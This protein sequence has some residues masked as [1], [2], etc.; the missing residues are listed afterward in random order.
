[1][2]LQ[3]VKIFTAARLGAIL[4][5]L[6]SSRHIIK[7]LT[8]VFFLPQHINQ[9]TNG[10]VSLTWVHRICWIRTSLGM[11]GFML[12]KLSPMYWEIFDYFIKMVEVNPVSSFEQI[13]QIR[14]PR[15]KVTGLLVPKKEIFER[16]YHISAWKP[17]WSCDPEHLNKFSSQHPTEA[18]YEI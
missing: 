17:S 16:F 3:S 13:W 8:E 6:H 11:H 5:S 18:P 9:R 10:S 12:Y 7:K 14:I 2:R 1:M 4:G 15:F